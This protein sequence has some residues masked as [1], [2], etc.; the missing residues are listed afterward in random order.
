MIDWVDEVGKDWGR[1]MRRVPYDGF[2]A[3]SVMGRIAE[4]GSVGAAIRSHVQVVPISD[5]PAD[6]LEF[7][8]AWA[9][10]EPKYK[11][12]L[13][14]QYVPV[15]ILVDRLEALDLKRSTYFD[16]LNA[17]HIRIWEIVDLQDR[18]RKVRSVRQVRN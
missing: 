6:I 12:V 4:E 1:Y 17:A 16:R 9:T 7:H 3:L 18:V 13:Y 14:V 10:V 2:P 11:K 15:C 5:V 8:R